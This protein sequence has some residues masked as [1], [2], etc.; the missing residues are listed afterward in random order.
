MKDAVVIETETALRDLAP[1]L[2]RESH[3]ALDTE[4]NSFYAYRERICL[5]QVSTPADDF[6]IDPLAVH[7]LSPLAPVMAS[8]AV[9]KIFHAASNDIGGLHRD[10]GF[11]F[12][13]V[14]DTALAFGMLG[15]EKLGLAGILQ[16]HFGVELDKRYQRHNWARRPLSADELDYARLD[17][18][19]LIPLRHILTERLSAE[20]LIDSARGAF[21]GACAQRL[22]RRPFRAGD[23]VRIR[24]SRA[25]PQ[26]GRRILRA[27]YCFR[28]DQARTSDRAP[29]RVLG[30]ETMLS[31]AA[32]PP[33]SLAALA[34]RKGVPQG[35]Q[36]GRGAEELF[37]VIQKAAERPGDT[38]TPAAAEPPRHDPRHP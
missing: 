20:C 22:E 36:R 9:E 6:I 7:D 28:E 19:Y 17:S 38:R 25:L 5:L 37:A 13:N 4:S 30:N 11:E 10:F 18:H 26:A 3:L 35:F 33:E 16:E 23:Y 21:R 1:R 32:S 31:L 24:G 2:A 12:E 34:R 14:F 8:P 15:R 29:F 27:L